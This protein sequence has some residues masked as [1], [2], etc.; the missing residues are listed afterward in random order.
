MSYTNG[1]RL[2]ISTTY[3]SNTSYSKTVTATLCLES[4][5]KKELAHRI[6]FDRIT[7]HDCKKTQEQ[8]DRYLYDKY[9]VSTDIDE[10]IQYI[11]GN[12]TNVVEYQ[13]SKIMNYCAETKYMGFVITKNNDNQYAA[14]VVYSSG[15]KEWF[16]QQLYE[17]D[18][19]LN[20]FKED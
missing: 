12:L 1:F 13:I 7:T 10:K 4:I 19:K 20:S 17:L 15:G 11:C 8:I 6:I 16:V 3:M 5:E 18:H 2:N 14:H 9:F